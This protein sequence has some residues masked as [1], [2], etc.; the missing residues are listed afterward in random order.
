MN[1]I[2]MFVARSAAIQ[3]RCHRGGRREGK[4]ESTAADSSE[5]TYAVKCLTY[6]NNNAGKH[7]KQLGSKMA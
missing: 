7:T 5:R 2:I 1:V 6:E 3:T 4:R